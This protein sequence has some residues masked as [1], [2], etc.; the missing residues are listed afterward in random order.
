MHQLSEGGGDLSK[1][2]TVADDIYS[3]VRQ[4]AAFSRC[5]EGEV[6]RR[7]LDKLIEE[8]GASSD[9]SAMPSRHFVDRSQRY[10]PGRPPRERGA[11]VEVGG[12]ILHVDS[13]RDLCENV[14]RF[15]SKNGK[16]ESVRSLLPYKTSSQRYLIAEKPIHPNGNR[17]VV[18]VQ[19]G[20]FYMEAHKS[21][22]TAIVQLEEFLAKLGVPFRYV[23]S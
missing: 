8:S 1:T 5:D 6:V 15:V 19:Q 20:G 23:S 22:R 11:R 2:I 12:E 17:F 14:L 18:P 9:T 13:V 7:L 16:R 10:L 4:L 21:Y 3:R